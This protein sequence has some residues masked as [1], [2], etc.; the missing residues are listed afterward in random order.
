MRTCL[1]CTAQVPDN[2]L[3]CG[4]CYWQLIEDSE[5]ERDQREWAEAEW[6]DR[7]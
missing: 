2:Q 1:D 7:T 4:R 5:E 3:R 6:E